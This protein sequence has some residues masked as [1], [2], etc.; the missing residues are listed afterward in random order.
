MSRVPCLKDLSAYGNGFMGR[1]GVRGFLGQS[2]KSTGDSEGLGSE[3]KELTISKRSGRLKSSWTVEHCHLLPIA[4]LTFTSIFGP[5]GK[6]RSAKVLK[7]R[8][9]MD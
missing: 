5:T 1:K 4:S 6:S 7:Q 9:N 8:H 3:Q 2:K